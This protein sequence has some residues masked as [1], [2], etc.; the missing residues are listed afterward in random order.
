MYWC[1]INLAKLKPYFPEFPPLHRSGL[2]WITRDNMWDLEGRTKA[3]AIFVLRFKGR[4]R[5]WDSVA[6]QVNFC[7][8]PGLVWGTRWDQSSSSFSFNFS[9][10]QARWIVSCMMMRTS[11]SCKILPLSKGNLEVVRDQPRFWWVL[12]G[13]SS[14]SQ[15]PLCP[16]FPNILPSDC[17][18]TDFRLQTQK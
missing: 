1:F 10:S 16:Y 11:F 14:V 6:A 3:A 4:C 8:L 5:A 15:M 17:F 12:I 18:S 7:E 9:G 2:M 13:S